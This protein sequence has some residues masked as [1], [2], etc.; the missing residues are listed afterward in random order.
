MEG[1]QFFSLKSR[2]TDPSDPKAYYSDA[3]GAGPGSPYDI[4][5]YLIFNLA[6]GGKYPGNAT[7]ATVLPATVSM[8]YVRIFGKP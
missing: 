5:F 2:A 7:E 6:V 8:D 3:Y 4:P 1:E